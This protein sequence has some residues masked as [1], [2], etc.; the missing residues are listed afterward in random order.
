MNYLL[1]ASQAGQTIFRHDCATGDRIAAVIPDPFGF[2]WDVEE[3]GQKYFSDAPFLCVQYM[4]SF[5]FPDGGIGIGGP[6]EAHLVPD[7]QFLH[8]VEFEAQNNFTNFANITL[9]SNEAST[10]TFDGK[11]LSGTP[12]QC[13]DSAW[14]IMTVNNIAAGP[15]IVTGA[16]DGLSVQVYGY[17]SDDDAYTNSSESFEGTYN[18]PDTAAPVAEIVSNCTDA[19][20]TF[21]DTGMDA[22][23]LSAIWIDSIYN[24]TF[25][26][27][28]AWQEGVPTAS[29][30]FISSVMDPTQPAY[31]QTTAYDVAGNSTTVTL[32]CTP[33]GIT[34][35]PAI[36]NVGTYVQ[37]AP[38][39]IAY[40]TIY[41]N[42]STPFAIDS[43]TLTN[44]STGFSLSDS[45]GGP[46]DTSAIPAHSRRIVRIQFGGTAIPSIDT[47]VVKNA[48][49]RFTG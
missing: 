20:V 42:G 21:T 32:R 43:I 40:D 39:N 27:D 16:G 31:L 47:L 45:I 38:E 18:S 33:P 19:T 12:A 46:I 26:L 7:Q 9:N 11:P 35:V 17:Y 5:T 41:N 4:N 25:A 37:P 28:S 6:S 14:E 30:Y 15:H 1:I 10:A 22:S 49:N 29:G 13:L 8:S 34:I 48:C 23:L 2:V 3:V 44:N 36:D 24:A